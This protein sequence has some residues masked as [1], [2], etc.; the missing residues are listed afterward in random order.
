M[1]AGTA[2][3]QAETAV[4]VREL[5]KAFGSQQVLKGVS[6]QVARGSALAVLGRSGQGK[7]VILKMLIGLIKP[8]SGEV[9][10]DGEEVSRLETQELNRVRRR[11]GFLFQ[12]GAL[13]DSL[14]VYENVAFPLRRHTRQDEAEIARNVN[15]RLE[16]VGLASSAHKMPS[17][18]SG[19]M[20][21]RVALAR[22]LVLD[23]RILLV[24]E[25]SA[26]LDPVTASEIDALLISRKQEDVTLV[27]VTHNIPSARAIADE[28]LFLHD[29]V[30]LARG[31]ADSLTSS[32]DEMVASFMRSGTG[33]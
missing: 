4:A 9:L 31:D 7:S 30:V 21:K 13:F 2:P 17:E 25:P 11:I 12:H 8:D 6:F 16:Q 28:L 27:V 10:I 29:G 26:G 3:A 14:S 20:R 18:L 23:P 1:Q 24:D 5:R 19:G 15:H 33:G 32:Q 22:A